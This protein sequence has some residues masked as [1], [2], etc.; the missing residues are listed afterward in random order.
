MVLSFEY[1]INIT[2][3]Q[4]SRGGFFQ[5]NEIPKK[6]RFTSMILYFWQ[7][8]TAEE[9]KAFAILGGGGGVV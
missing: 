7:L 2:A 9:H 3:I 8:H 6:S 1:V 4:L 5:E